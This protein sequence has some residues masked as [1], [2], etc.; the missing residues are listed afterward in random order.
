MKIITDTGQEIEISV[1]KIIAV[2]IEDKNNVKK[3]KF[4]YYEELNDGTFRMTY[5]K[6]MLG[7]KK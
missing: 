2:N 6:G 5:T 4:I 3:K 1:S 7:E